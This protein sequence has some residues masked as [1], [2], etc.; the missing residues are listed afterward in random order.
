MSHFPPLD[1]YPAPNKDWQYVEVPPCD[2]V[3]LD[4]L[5]KKHVIS[6]LNIYQTAWALV[7]RC[8]IGSNSVYFGHLMPVPNRC[9]EINTCHVVIDA[10]KSIVEV[11]QDLAL[12][13][14]SRTNGV[15]QKTLH[16]DENNPTDSPTKHVY[17]TA[18]RY[19][20]LG[21]LNPL[22]CSPFFQRDIVKGSSV[23]SNF[24]LRISAD[25]R[26]R[27]KL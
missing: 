12:E 13:A 25:D 6:A 11:S 1:A 15:L 8:Y 26:S 14:T 22:S 9:P 19:Q 3:R 23:S 27:S 17:N 5:C 20:E 2:Q 16:Q 7:L 21:L 24:F 18:L 10:S 4:K